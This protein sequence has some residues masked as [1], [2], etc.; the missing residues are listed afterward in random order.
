[1]DASIFQIGAKLM[2]KEPIEPLRRMERGLNRSIT[3][4][5]SRLGANFLTC[6]AKATKS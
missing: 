4:R 5:G 2:L 3:S 6:S 1:M